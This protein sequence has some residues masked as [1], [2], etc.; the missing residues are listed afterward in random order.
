MAK[1]NEEI[2]FKVNKQPVDDAVNSVKQ[3]NQA[4]KDVNATTIDLTK[5]IS[6]A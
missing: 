5:N 3:L 1:F 2:D 6:I 4:T